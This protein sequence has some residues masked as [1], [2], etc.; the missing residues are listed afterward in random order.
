MTPKIQRQPATSST[1]CPRLGAIIG[2]TMN[3]MATIDCSRA[4]RSPEKRSRMMAAG[5]TIRPA[6]VS[7]SNARST[8][9][10]VKLVTS[11]QAAVMAI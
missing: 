7:P 8:S 9:S 6:Q 1:A 11:A 2:T 4:M 5:R 3:T 10:R